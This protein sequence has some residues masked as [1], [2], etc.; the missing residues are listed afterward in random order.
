[1]SSAMSA[2]IAREQTAQAQDDTVSPFGPRQAPMICAN[3]SHYRRHGEGGSDVHPFASGKCS[4]TRSLRGSSGGEFL[5]H[6]APAFRIGLGTAMGY[7]GH[8]QCDDALGLQS[9]GPRI[10]PQL[11]IGVHLLHRRLRRGRGRTMFPALNEWR[12][13]RFGSTSSRSPACAGVFERSGSA[14]RHESPGLLSSNVSILLDKIA[15]A[16]RV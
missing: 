9:Y 14:R 7:S 13:A 11:P 4:G 16:W 2:K 5:R 6:H 3:R 15:P 10:R 1:M 12:A 8:A